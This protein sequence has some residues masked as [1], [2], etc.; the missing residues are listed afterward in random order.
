MLRVVWRAL[1]VG[2]SLLLIDVCCLLCVVM[3]GGVAWWRCVLPVVV[4]WLTF[5]VRWLMLAVR[6][7]LFVVRCC[8]FLVVCCVLLLVVCCVLL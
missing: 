5:V 4:K 6:C 8:V 3:C 1:L 7:L 2:C